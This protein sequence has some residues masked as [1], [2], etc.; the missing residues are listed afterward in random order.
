MWL[1]A[2]QTARVND[3]QPNIEER[4]ETIGGKRREKLMKT[5]TRRVQKAQ[6]KTEMLCLCATDDAH[7]D[8]S[9]SF[10]VDLIATDQQYNV[11]ADDCPQL[12]DPVADLRA[13]T[14]NTCE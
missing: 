9:A 5:D 14:E 3:W 13:R 12:F 1:K 10:E 6:Q 2:K 7:T 11:C 8:L 4:K